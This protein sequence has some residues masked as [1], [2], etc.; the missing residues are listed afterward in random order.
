MIFTLRNRS[1][2]RSLQLG[3]S[4]LPIGLVLI[5]L[6]VHSASLSLFFLGTL[7]AGCGFGSSFLG[8]VR[9]LVPLALPHERAGLMSAYYVLSYLAF[10][11]PALL[12]GHLTSSFGLLATTDVYGLALVV[13][14]VGGLILISRQILVSRINLNRSASE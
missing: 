7:V 2:R 4:L 11:L 5:L 3:A 6:G 9:S 1:A 12:A 10:C 14:S 8:A 13:L